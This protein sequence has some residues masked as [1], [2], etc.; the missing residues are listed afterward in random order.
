MRQYV[1]HDPLQAAALKTESEITDIDIMLL[2]IVR[3][4][5][6]SWVEG[7]LINHSLVSHQA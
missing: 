2:V 1:L 3:L 6:R 7:I 4:M 5:E